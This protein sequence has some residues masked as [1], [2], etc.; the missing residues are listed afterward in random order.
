[1]S[2]LT[3][4]EHDGRA[5]GGNATGTEPVTHL[6]ERRR[7]IGELHLTDYVRVLS[8]RRWPALTVAASVL[9]L[10]TL[11]TFTTTPIYE[12][13]VQIL[14]EK[15]ASNVVMFKEAVEQSQLTDDYYQTQ[16]RIL[17]S[18]AL[19][20]RTI[21][22]LNLWN[23]PEFADAP[24]RLGGA[25][26]KIRSVFS[27]A[28]GGATRGGPASVDETRTQS[29]VI[30]RFLANLTA[31]PVRNSRLVD[32]RI[33]A[34][35]AR[36]AAQVANQLAKAYIEQSL[37]FKY[38]ASKE[39]SEWLNARVTDQRK[40]VEASEQALQSYREES[41]TASLGEH[42]NIVLQKL[43]DLNAAV[44]RAR[45]ERLQKKAAYDQIPALQ[46]GRAELDT[47]PAVIN[48]AFVQQQKIALADLQR[49]QAQL[50]EKL[51]PNHPD[52]LRLAQ[53]ARTVDA[54]IKVEIGKIVEAM[55]NDYQQSAAQE[56]SLTQA[57]D[58]QKLE[59][60]AL[61]RE[62]I[63]YSAI[64]RNVAA[65]RQIFE[66]LMQRAKETGISGALKTSNI[67]VVDAAET[68][69]GPVSPDILANLLVAIL[70]GGLLAAGVAF[71]LEYL[72]NRLK[73]PEEMQ[74]H[75]GLPF[76]GMIPA[77]FDESVT[78]LL[79]NNGVPPSFSES[80]LSLR[81]N[82]LFSAMPEGTRSLAVTSTGPGEGKTLVSANLAIGLAHAGFRVLLIDAD[83]RRPRIHT[84]F[85]RPR[86]PGLS[87]VLVANATFAESVQSTEVEG[88][89][90]MAAGTSP[91]NPADLL[92]ARRFSD[93][94]ASLSTLFDWV[95]VD[96]PPVMA[97]TDPS[98][99]AHVTDGVLF[100]VGAEMTKRNVAR[101]AIEQLER[102][103]AKFIGAVLN[104]VDL[105]HNSYY[106]SAYYARGY[107][108]YLNTQAAQ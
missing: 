59:A 61:N 101:N 72:D 44:T 67:R 56:R 55:R 77:L 57:L 52:M 46:N 91:P 78:H 50:S 97:V 87:N 41:E 6:P 49:Q 83:M 47:I 11:Y 8:K 51:G 32:V 2:N 13:R 86:Q 73:N 16:Y 80:F 93:F 76:L 58:Q 31:A 34:T 29:R 10:T 37:E 17:Q 9:V 65:D 18:R 104:R 7:A 108:D 15:E 96:T 45:T 89:S 85:N 38:L 107:G 28:N 14:I 43:A 92:G 94:L 60:L 5:A 3:L 69:R 27:A 35:D 19:A 42:Q 54:K 62:G 22:D 88:L 36:L 21:N 74:R 53:A 70:G 103:H 98:V 82:V 95:I 84:V 23:S 71:L 40:Q 90:V 39:A 1:M 100:V 24:G 105:K 48:N 75:L 4:A 63:R 81:T 33:T 99:V 79:I 102:G 30:D 66:G 25:A 64:E 106:Y 26:R 20:R 12:A 68:P